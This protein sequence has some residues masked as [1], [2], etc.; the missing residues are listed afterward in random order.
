MRSD[1]DRLNQS[2]GDILTP[3]CRADFGDTKCRAVVP[4]EWTTITAVGD[5]F[6]ITV[7]LAAAHANDF[8]N[9]GQIEFQSGVLLGIRPIEIFDYVGATGALTLLVPLPEL[10]TIGDQVV[11]KRGC[12]KLLKSDDT[13]KPTCYGYGNVIN[14]QGEPRM[15]TSDQYLKVPVPGSNGA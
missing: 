7:D 8:Y 4:Y 15:P 11:I 1:S 13:A 2:V 9:Y 12:S 10:P 6:H 5:D 14:F 3:T